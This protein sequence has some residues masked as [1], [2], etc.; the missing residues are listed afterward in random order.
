MNT[1]IL[2]Q[3]MKINEI[4]K[5]IHQNNIDKGFWED[6][7]TKNVGELL[8]L[9]VSELSEALEA[10]RKHKFANINGFEMEKG[11]HVHGDKLNF[12][13]S[14]QLH[15]KDTFEDEIADAVIRL[16]DIA[17]GLDFDLEFFIRHKLDY[18]K[19]RPYKHN[20]KY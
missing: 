14:F 7:D 1:N 13:Q 16:F 3:K 8:M 10:H 5:E 20:K 9:V 15:I 2:N 17:S 6:K 12:E 11:Y 19:T 18:N 4:S